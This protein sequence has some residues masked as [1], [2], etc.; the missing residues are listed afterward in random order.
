MEKQESF[1]YKE[2]YTAEPMSVGDHTEMVK[3]KEEN[4]YFSNR[5]A[6]HII[7]PIKAQYLLLA[8]L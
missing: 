3:T 4:T 6:Y 8:D 2:R 1:P 5:I 7:F